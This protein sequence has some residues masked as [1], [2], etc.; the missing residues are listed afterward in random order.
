MTI[1]SFLAGMMFRQILLERRREKLRTHPPATREAFAREVESY[2]YHSYTNTMKGT[3]T[4]AAALFL[5]APLIWKLGVW[6]YTLKPEL[7]EWGL[8]WAMVSFAGGCAAAYGARMLG[9]ALAYRR[10]WK[11][12]YRACYK[13]KAPWD[14]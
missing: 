12:L 14:A 7:G 10:V 5:T 6:A 1:W 8:I 11:E 9:A 13:D 4:S 2:V 3:L